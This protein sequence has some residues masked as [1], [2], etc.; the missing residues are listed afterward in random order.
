MQFPVRTDDY[1]RAFFI[2]T[3]D[4]MTMIPYHTG[5]YTQE[6]INFTVA[7]EE[8]DDLLHLS[9]TIRPERSL[10][11]R[12]LGL[13]LG[14]DCCMETF[15]DWNDKYFPTALRCE[16]RGFWGCF[17][18][19]LGAR[20]GICAPSGIVSWCNEYSDSGND[21][22]GHRIYT[23]S[24][25][26]INTAP[27]P[28]RHPVSPE[29]NGQPLYC[30]LY[31]AK[32]NS[33]Q[34]LFEFVERY[35]GIHV[36]QVSKFTLEP[37]E[38]LYI[39]GKPYAGTLRDGVNT[40]DAPGCAEVTVYVRRPWRYYLTCANVS[41][42]QCQQK[43]GTNCESWYG[44]FSRVLY[45]QK[46]GT[47]AQVQ[48]LTDEFDRFFHVLTV[49]RDGK[50][51][52]HP[53]ALPVRL[54][55]TAVMLSLL[56][57]FYELT[58]DT[59]YLDKADQLA[60]ELL[61]AQVEDGSYRKRRRMHYTCVVY[62]AKSM[63]ELAAAERQAGRHDRASVHESSAVRAVWELARSLDD[64]G[65]EGQM[66]FEDGMLTCECLQL[67]C[68]ALQLPEGAERTRLTDAAS[69][70]LRK[71]RC[72][73]QHILPD[74]RVR[75][76]TARFWEARYDVN[77]FA[78]MLN[79]PHGWTSWKTYATYYLY[80]LTG[81]PDYL[82]DT[83]DTVGACMQCVDADGVLHWGYTADPCV[84]GM[85]LSPRSVPGNIVME[86][87][88]VGECYLPMISHWWRQDDNRRILQYL[89]PWDQPDRWDDLY[90]GS[91]DNDVHEHFKCLMETVFGKAF[92]HETADGWLS[93]NCRS[94]ETGWCTDDPDVTEWIVF[95]ET[96]ETVRIAGRTESLHS[97]F[98]FIK[99]PET[100]LTTAL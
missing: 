50:Y 72:L 78:N 94:T 18:T 34:A 30:D 5:T 38:T 91:C 35:A 76:G 89:D 71:H 74:C 66:T 100:P 24:V 63:L 33:G 40:I 97:G 57:D 68:L 67:G 25:D 98:N 82:R 6:D 27:Q 95:A 90:G 26:F 7:E 92:L 23:V 88:V 56:A 15:P 64:I 20:I 51:R 14:I 85:R 1:R 96:A 44:Y 86:E 17:M 43:P 11:C 81:N 49:K 99:Y 48:A 41:A 60:E 13:R 29:P 75:G 93:F 31:L 53:E 8:T 84:R 4:G 22:V 37:G 19:P 36:P 46:F 10:N 79:T 69:Y 32:V 62:P 47:P 65:T 45:E 80:L 28:T 73:Q 54:Q 70:I 77:F 9:M 59:D 2:E 42:Q 83:M 21:I 87:S 52:M 55:N 58:G 16:K 39:D 3:A 61:W 12:R